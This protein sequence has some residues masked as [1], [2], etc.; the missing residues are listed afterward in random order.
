MKLTSNTIRDLEFLMKNKN[1]KLSIW[2]DKSVGFYVKI[3]GVEYVPYVATAK[4]LEVAIREALK[5]MSK[6]K[7]KVK[8]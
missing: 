6:G 1:V 4:V 2:A 5:A 7:L 8:E 3:E